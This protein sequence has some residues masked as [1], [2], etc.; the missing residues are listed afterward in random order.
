MLARVA[1]ALRAC[2]RQPTT[3][4]TMPGSDAARS[5]DDPS[6]LAS[7]ADVERVAEVAAAAPD[8]L[9][10]LGAADGTPRQLA[11]DLVGEPGAPGAPTVLL[12]HGPLTRA[13]PDTRTPPSPPPRGCASSPSTDPASAT[14]PPTPAAMPPPSRPTP[15]TS[16]TTSRS[17]ASTCSPGLP[18]PVGRS[19]SA[20][21]PRRAFGRSPSSAGWFP[22]RRSCRPP[23]TPRCEPPPEKL[24]WAWSTP[25]LNWVPSSP[26][27]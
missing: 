18:A 24:A 3:V 13:S 10:P 23:T 20:P 5:S 22:S 16:S 27:R 17:T 26:R 7:A 12:V 21:S 25:R 6:D 8:L 1:T 11:A 2:V 15:S 4:V 9:L 19:P 14:A